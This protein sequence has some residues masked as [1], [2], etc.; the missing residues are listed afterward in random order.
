MG[1]FL[2][3]ALVLLAGALFVTIP[4]SLHLYQEWK[5]NQKYTIFST[6]ITVS[7]LTILL[8]LFAYRILLDISLHYLSAMLSTSLIN[9]KLYII[10]FSVLLI[11]ALIVHTTS[12]YSLK[13]FRQWRAAQ[14]PLYFSL[15]ILLGTISVFCFAFLYEYISGFY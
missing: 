9:I 14:K 4:Q 1:L 13:C 5:K 11:F 10:P 15:S 2:F 6:L 8:F 3:S 7:G 12:T